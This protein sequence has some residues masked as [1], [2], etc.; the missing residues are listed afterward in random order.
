[1]DALNFTEPIK[2]IELDNSR[3]TTLIVDPTVAFKEDKNFHCLY[4][5]HLLWRMN[6]KFAVAAHG[7]SVMGLEPE[8]PL[9]VFRVTR[10]CGV[11][12][13]YYIVYFDGT[14]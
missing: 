8:V 9:S 3:F 4:C 11:C 7:A 14:R 13:Q 2:L 12:R 5:G 10:M 6:R 1:M